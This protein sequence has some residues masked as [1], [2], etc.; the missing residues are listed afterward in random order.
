[1]VMRRLRFGVHGQ[2]DPVPGT[3]P[4]DG[5]LKKVVRRNS[6]SLDSKLNVEEAEDGSGLKN[7]VGRVLS[8]KVD[9]TYD[10]G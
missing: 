8:Q 3:S 2:V 10:K 6:N 9:L 7:A 5:I 1:M 4:L